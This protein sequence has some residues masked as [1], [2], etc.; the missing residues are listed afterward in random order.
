MICASF[1]RLGHF[2]RAEPTDDWKAFP[3]PPSAADSTLRPLRARF[4]EGFRSERCGEFG[5]RIGGPPHGVHIAVTF[6]SSTK[7][8]VRRRAWFA[9]CICKRISLGLEVH[10]IL[11]QAEGGPD[12]EENAAPLCPSCHRIYGGN[13]ELRARIREMRDAWYEI[14][15]CLFTDS[16]EPGEVFRSIHEVFSLEELER[17]TIHNP[18]YVLGS[19]RTDGGLGSTRFSFYQ[20]EYVHPLIVKELLGWISDSSATIVGVDLEAANRSNRFFG[21][22]SVKDDG[23]VAVVERR[24][25]EASFVYKHVATTPSGVDIVECHD[26]M[27]GS[28]VFGTIAL[29]C[30]EKDRVA[31]ADAQSLSSRDRLVLK[32]LGQFPLGDRYRGEILYRNGVLVVGPDRGWFNRGEEAAWRL[33][34]L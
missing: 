3:S 2:F 26:W 28:G 14:C 17:L 9:C 15:E 20:D 6:L 27:G 18:T 34:V 29:F 16:R 12:S 23:A 19:E 21:E 8:V 7:T 33:P 24:E 25:A 31:E 10:H 30:I 5:K 11:P 13:P 4:G 32:I 22:F 1:S